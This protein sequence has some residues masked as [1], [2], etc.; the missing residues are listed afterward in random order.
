[1]VSRVEKALGCDIEYCNFKWFSSMD[2]E[3]FGEGCCQSICSGEQKQSALHE[4][5]EKVSLSSTVGTEGFPNTTVRGREC[6]ARAALRSGCAVLSW[7]AGAYLLLFAL[8]Q[9]H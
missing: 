6:C 7:L 3:N 5:I 2:R 9:A 8:S 4:R 1:M